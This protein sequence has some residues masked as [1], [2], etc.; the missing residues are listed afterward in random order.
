M[1]EEKKGFIAWV[2]AHKKELIIAGVGVPA[3]IAIILGIKNKVP[4]GSTRMN[5][6]KYYKES[7]TY[8]KAAPGKK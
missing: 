2:K 7:R 6:M 5:I 1:N 3:I 4:Q 8:C